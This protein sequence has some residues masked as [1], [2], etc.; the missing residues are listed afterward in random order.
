MA[1]QFRDQAP[2]ADGGG[3]CQE[4]SSTTGLA[5]RGSQQF[6]GAH[7]AQQQVA[8]SG[9]A[10]RSGGCAPCAHAP[11]KGASRRRARPPAARQPQAA[12]RG[13]D[14]VPVFDSREL[15]L[16]QLMAAR[17]YVVL[18]P[19]P[20][21]TPKVPRKHFADTDLPQYA[22]PL[23][24]TPANALM[25]WSAR[26][27]REW[28][29]A[30]AVSRECDAD[31]RPELLCWLF[32]E[33]MRHHEIAVSFAARLVLIYADRMRID[34]TDDAISEITADVITRVF[35]RRFHVDVRQRALD[36][37]LTQRR[38]RDLVDAGERIMLRTIR[39]GFER[40]LR[41]CA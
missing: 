38:Y 29:A 36:C 24:M 7:G 3:S 34:V 1:D 28:A 4:I 2:E 21:D 27:L 15:A 10:P 14:T 18:P 8:D 37:K 20:D 41:A 5:T 40:Y 17:G 22:D 30:L 6:F 19:A 32:A 33:D 31:I 39:T 16:E 12:T 35:Y 13:Y 11:P 26:S 23:P 9:V 25:R